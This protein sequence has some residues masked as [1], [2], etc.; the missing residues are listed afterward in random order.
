MPKCRYC[1]TNEVTE[2]DR[3]TAWRCH[4]NGHTV[5]H[6]ATGTC[7]A[8]HPDGTVCGE[9]L[10][11]VV[12]TKYSCATCRARRATNPRIVRPLRQ[13]EMR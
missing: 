9:P 10:G 4:I 2:A 1:G 12:G 8:I 11:E 7:D 3:E 6:D 13:E 5:I